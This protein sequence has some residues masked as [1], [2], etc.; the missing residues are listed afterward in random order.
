ML[1]LIDDWFKTS[2]FPKIDLIK[3]DIE[4]NELA[5]LKGMEEILQKQKPVSDCGNKSR[6]S[7]NVQFKTI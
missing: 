2:G 4:G 7:F 3:L 6:N 1:W 5:A